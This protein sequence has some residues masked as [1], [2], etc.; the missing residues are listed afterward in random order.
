MS[1]LQLTTTTDRFLISMD[2]SVIKRETLLRLLELF[3]LEM[4][5]E[6]VD[7][8]ASVEDLGEEIVAE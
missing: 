7:F 1:A 4:L 5:A 8:D 3:R 2:R 6:Q